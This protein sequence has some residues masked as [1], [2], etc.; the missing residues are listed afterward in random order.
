[1]LSLRTIL[2]PTDF[3]PCSEAAFTAA[4]ALAQPL[5]A[6]VAVLHVVTPALPCE[7]APEPTA[8]NLWK[9]LLR[10]QPAAPEVHV[11]H[12]LEHGPPV[13]KT[14]EVARQTGCDLIVLG[15]HGRGAIARQLF[16]IGSVAEAVVHNAPC[17]VLTV[18]M[19]LPASFAAALPQQQ[20]VEV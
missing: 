13:Q 11:E 15:T 20:T 5:G 3:S 9:Q 8:E 1:M 7:T 14:L 6:T 10:F 12:L 19:P 16:G 18:K 2:C 4:C 17:P